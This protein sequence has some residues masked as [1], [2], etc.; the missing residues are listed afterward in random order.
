MEPEAPAGW[1]FFDA[2]DFPTGLTTDPMGRAPVRHVVTAVVVGHEGA[3]WLPRLTEALWA[4]AR[5]PDRLIA[6]DTGS[7]DDTAQL[8]AEMPGVEPVVSLS[9]RTGF[10]TA[11][12][13]G[14]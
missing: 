8:L 1:D 3:A 5:R 9:A 13:R 6:I 14:L 10:G 7:T 11:V 2:V 4:M 12:T